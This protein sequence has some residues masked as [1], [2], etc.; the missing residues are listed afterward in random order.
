MR[1]K[2]QAFSRRDVALIVIPILIL[3]GVAGWLTVKSIRLAPPRRIRITSGPAGSS[4][5]RFADR[6]KEIIERYGIKVD[7]LPSAGA[8]ENL[9][10]LS[11]RSVRVD[12][13][14]VQSGL[15]EGEVPGLM[16]LG[17]LAEQPLMV[18]TR[19]AQQFERLSELRGKRL[20]IG[21]PGTG[22]HSLA[23]KLLAASNLTVPPTVLADQSGEAAA[24]AL[25]GGSVD[26]IF[27]MGDAFTPALSKRMRELPDVHL[28]SFR[29]ADAYT[30]KFPFLSKLTLPEG[31]LDLD[32]DYPPEPVQLVGP[33]VELVA[34]DTLHPALS[35]LL[36][37]AA[38]E[39]HGSAGLFRNA[40]EFPA[41]LARD[42]PLSHDAERYYKSGEQ[43]LYKR[44]PF[45]LAS[46][47]DRLL[48]LLVPLFVAIIPV[49]RLLPAL[50]RWRVRSRIYRWYGALMRL[51]RDLQRETVPETRAD[52]LKQLEDIAHSVNELRAPASFGDQVY[53]LRDHV[54]NVR[55]RV[56]G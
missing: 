23:L 24:Q 5:Q 56:G 53:V 15:K 34:R 8:I 6:Y 42:F 22:A 17:S 47:I 14:F 35:D 40:G 28:M 43:F 11:D 39:V 41:P 20:A 54:A 30:R 18:Y 36:I 26:A 25:A 9:Q 48:V 37:S 38:K 55:R 27:V 3:V 45:W 16:S 10:R 21:A 49:T 44:L 1:A 33:T 29:L 32:R 19:G 12:V 46:L 4:Y 50:Y 13:G 51:E 31:A 2:W 7:I 52:L